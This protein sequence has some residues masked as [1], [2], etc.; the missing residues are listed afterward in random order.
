[1][2]RY[3]ERIRR[4]EEARRA[5]LKSIVEFMTK[6]TVEVINR[7]VSDREVRLDILRDLLEHSSKALGADSGGPGR[8]G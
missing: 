6:G 1:M 5:E 8:N 3:R 4:L 2:T 7:H